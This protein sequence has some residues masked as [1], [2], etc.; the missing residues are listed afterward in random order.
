VFYIPPDGADTGRV[1]VALCA[2][3]ERKPSEQHGDYDSTPQQLC[4]KAKD[5]VASRDIGVS[6][7]PVKHKKH[8]L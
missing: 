4:G 6:A 1:Y 3:I 5:C 2:R 7:A 8:S